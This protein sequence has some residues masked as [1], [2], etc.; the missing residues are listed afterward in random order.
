MKLTTKKLTQIIREEVENVM[1]E[2]PYG[3]GVGAA[4]SGYDPKRP[5]S[6]AEED[7]ERKSDPAYTPKSKVS[8]PVGTFKLISDFIGE[9]PEAP[10]EGRENL[11]GTKEGLIAFFNKNPTFYNDLV[12]QADTAYLDPKAGDI[13]KALHT[14]NGLFSKVDAQ[15]V[16][17]I[18]KHPSMEPKAKESQK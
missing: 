13:T 7:W 4:P 9:L 17:H 18:L 15:T 11:N 6:D 8:I 14:G 10:G 5:S 16:L 3:T 1:S 12:N 2:A